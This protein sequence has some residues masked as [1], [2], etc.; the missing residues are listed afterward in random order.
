MNDIALILIGVA[1]VVIAALFAL[2]RMSW[3][4][5]EPDEALIISGFRSAGS[6]DGPGGR[7]GFRIVTGR[8]ALVI[9]GV[10]KV[11]TLSLEAH[12]SEI[13]VPCVSQQKIRLDLRGVVVY[14]VGDDLPSIA[15]AA[16]RFLDR[17]AAE[18]ESKVQNV[19]VGH[20]R[21]I[22][23][24]MTVEEMIS[25]QDKFAQ[26]VRD[27]C[28]QEM[29]SFGLVIDSFQIQA[30]TSPSNYIENLAV[31]HQAEVERNARIARAVAD[32]E[33]VAQ[34]QTA[35]AQIAA[36]VRDTE[37]KK[38]GFQA[39]VDR[40]TQDA[41]QQGPLAQATARQAVVQEETKVAELQAQQKE[42]QLQV[43][44]RRPADAE[45]YKQTTLATAGRDVS[46]RHAEAAAQEVRLH[47]EAQ[48]AATKLQAEAQASATRVNGQAEADAIRARGL[49]EAD[50]IKARMEAEA[51]GIERR[52]AALSQNQEAVIAQQIAEN[53]P[54]IVQAAASPFEHVGQFTV[55]NGAEGVTGA[56][57]Q[58][59]QQA[60]ALAGLARHTLMPEMSS[61]NGHG[62]AGNGAATNGAG[63]NGANGSAGAK[64]ASKGGAARHAVAAQ[65]EAGGDANGG[66]A[67]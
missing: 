34:E 65:T 25:D 61:R 1:V 57:A 10:T 45:A 55:L 38:A 14:K 53:L 9:P 42:Q 17:P 12:E 27:R 18:L 54:A 56:L 30:I 7:M 46:I 13:T 5:A 2:F 50:A 59:I 15:N 28:S 6:A 39:E 3:R 37:I 20:L 44:V 43:D 19:F 22:A 41:Q 66:S 32:R 8:G 48:A 40:A 11:R 4:I 36:S 24:S 23:G 49:A 31:P 33:A 62:E 47:A 58:I 26:Q 52:A 63:T 29:E 35:A 64:Q 67:G 51:S 60:G 21:A 16:R